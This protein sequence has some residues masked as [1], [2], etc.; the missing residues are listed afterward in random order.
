MWVKHF[1]I[2]MWHNYKRL[3]IHVP[4]C[5]FVSQFLDL[6]VNWFYF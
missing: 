4:E 1:F 2:S 5:K 3:H 6:S